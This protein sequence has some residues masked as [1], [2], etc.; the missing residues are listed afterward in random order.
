MRSFASYFLINITLLKGPTRLQDLGQTTVVLLGNEMERKGRQHCVKSAGI[1]FDPN[2][3][4]SILGKNRSIWFSNRRIIYTLYKGPTFCNFVETFEKALVHFLALLEIKRLC[5]GF[6]KITV[7]ER[8][9]FI[10]FSASLAS[11]FIKRVRLRKI[12]E[13]PLWMRPAQLVL[14]E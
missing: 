3:L 1:G 12:S 13:L 10:C 6:A 11:G 9:L 2:T 14:L 8:K 5:E 7:Q 4:G